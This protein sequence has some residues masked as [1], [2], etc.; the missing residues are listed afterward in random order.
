MVVAHPDHHP[1]VSVGV[2]VVLLGCVRWGRVGATVKIRLPALG[3][4]GRL[5]RLDGL[6][7]ESAVGPGR[8]HRLLGEALHR[9]GDAGAHGVVLGGHEAPRLRVVVAV[10]AAER[11]RRRQQRVGGASGRA[12]RSDSRRQVGPERAA[13]ADAGVGFGLAGVRVVAVQRAV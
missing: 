2:V 10:A 9:V 6:G 12:R 3:H 7:G 11:L 1:A 13:V 5:G 4:G 8:R